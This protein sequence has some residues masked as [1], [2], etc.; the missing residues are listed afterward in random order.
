MDDSY[1]SNLKNSVFESNLESEKSILHRF[2]D[3]T[4]EFTTKQIFQT[5]ND[6][7][8]WVRMVGRQH[9]FVVVI[10]KSAHGNGNKLPKC[11]L[12]CDRGGKYRPP[13]YLLPGQTLQKNTETKKCDCPFALRGV[14]IPLRSAP[15]P[16]EGIMWGVLVVRGYHNHEPTQYLK[17]H[18]YPSRLKPDEKQFVLDLADNIAPRFILS[19]L[20]E[21]D[22]SNI[23]GIRSIYNAIYAEKRTRRG[24]LNSVQYAPSQL[25][26]KD[27]IKESRLVEYSP[28]NSCN[29][30]VD[31]PDELHDER[32][33][34]P[35]DSDEGLMDRSKCTSH[36][37][38]VTHLKTSASEK[39]K[40]KEG[41]ESSDSIQKDNQTESS[42]A[43]AK[44]SHSHF[45][46]SAIE[47]LPSENDAV[48]SCS[49]QKNKCIE[50]T[51]S[52][53]GCGLRVTDDGNLYLPCTCDEANRN[54]GDGEH[55]QLDLSM[56]QR[57][58][59]DLNKVTEHSCDK[60]L[61]L[62]SGLGQ[63]V[64]IKKRENVDLISA[65]CGDTV[66]KN[67]STANVFPSSSCR[68]T[69]DCS[70]EAYCTC[71][72]KQRVDDNSAIQTQRCS[73]HDSMEVLL[74]HSVRVNA[75]PDCMNSSSFLRSDGN[76]DVGCGLNADMN[77]NISILKEKSLP[78]HTSSSCRP[79][80]S[81]FAEYWVPVHISNLQ[82]EQYSSILLSNS[83][84]LRSCLKKD[85]VDV[86]R[87]ILVSTL[88]CCNHPYVI[89]P[90]LQPA[91]TK[92]CTFDEI[93]D[94]GGK[95]SGKLQLL[96]AMLLKLKNQGLRLLILY[97]PIC[98]VGRDNIG[99]ILEDYLRHRFGIDSYER[100]DGFGCR[101]SKKQAACNTFNTDKG[102]LFFLLET[103]ACLP[104]IK[105]S[106]V[107]AVIIYNSDWNP[108]NDLRALQKITIESNMEQINVF[109]LYSFCTI[110]ENML[111]LTKK[112]IGFGSN[113]QSV[114]VSS[115]HMLLMLGA[116]YLFSKLDEFHLD[117]DPDVIAGIAFKDSFIRDVHQELFSLSE[118]HRNEVSVKFISKAEQDEGKY[119]KSISL[120]GELTIQPAV[121]ESPH[122]FWG[123]LLDER[124]PR[125]KYLSSPP[126]RNRKRVQYFD[127][128]VRHQDIQNEE[129]PRKRKK[130]GGKKLDAALLNDGS[131]AGG[132]FLAVKKKGDGLPAIPQVDVLES[133][134]KRKLLLEQ[135]HLLLL[136]KPEILKL[137][138]VLQLPENV[139]Q[140]AERY[141]DYV[142]NNH[143]VSREPETILQAFKISVC[144]TAA[145]L[146]G[147]IVDHKDSLVLARE[148]LDF[149][150]KEDEAELIFLKMQ[151]LKEVF[152]LDCRES[153]SLSQKHLSS[154]PNAHSGKM[155]ANAK[156]VAV[157]NSENASV[158]V[159]KSPDLEPICTPR[160]SVDVSQ[161]ETSKKVQKIGKKC[162]K[163]MELLKA[164]QIKEL[165]EFQLLWEEEKARLERMHS[166]E[167]ILIRSIHD[168][169]PI[170]GDKLKDLAN[171]SA[172][173]RQELER[174]MIARLKDLQ[175]RQQADKN[176]EQQK[177]A[178]WLEEVKSWAQVQLLNKQ[179][180]PVNMETR[181]V[182]PPS[183]QIRMPEG[184][185][186]A[187]SLSE[188]LVDER[189][190]DGVACDGP[191]HHVEP[192]GTYE[193]ARKV[194]FVAS[195]TT[196]FVADKHASVHE[197]S[198]DSPSAAVPFLNGL[199]KLP[200]TQGLPAMP[201]DEA[202]P[203]WQPE[204]VL[205]QWPDGAPAEAMGS[206]DPTERWPDAALAE[207][208]G[209]T[210]PTEMWHDAAP[211]EA[212]G[213][214]DPEER[215][216]SN[217]GIQQYANQIDARNPNGS[218]ALQTNPEANSLASAEPTVMQ[219][220][221]VST[222][223][224]QP[225]PE[226]HGELSCQ[227]FEALGDQVEAVSEMDDDVL[228]V[229]ASLLLASHDESTDVSAT[230]VAESACIP[231]FR[232][233][234]QTL[235][236]I[237][238]H[239]DP[240]RESSI[241]QKNILPSISQDQDLA[242]ILNVVP[243]NP[244]SECEVPHTVANPLRTE[245][246]PP[247]ARSAHPQLSSLPRQVPTQ[248]VTQLPSD[249][250][251]N[252]LDRIRRQKDL[253]IRAHDGM[254]LRLESD[255]DKEIDEVV[256]QIRRKYNNLR[257]EA[258]ASFL[259]EKK[260]FDMKENK[261]Q[262][263]KILAEAFRSKYWLE[264]RAASGTQ[265]GSQQQVMSL[266]RTPPHL[267]PFRP[268][269]PLASGIL[270]TPV[271]D[272]TFQLP[273]SSSPV[274]P[275]PTSPFLLIP[276][277]ADPQTIRPRLMASQQTT[278]SIPTV[279]C[280]RLPAQLPLQTS[281]PPAP[282]Q[283]LLRS[284]Q[285]PAPPPPHR[286]T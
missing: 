39:L 282:F 132:G 110:E 5:R 103:H 279:S 115:C 38:D 91:L 283:P 3:Y 40:S 106:S 127:G 111:A 41:A 116:S 212:M 155:D 164:K 268:V 76:P 50:E 99:D 87:E 20:K 53:N 214:T 71:S 10:D 42:D 119:Q 170:R 63:I 277:P 173:K 34:Q 133:E 126:Q 200:A 147:Q 31:E 88:K 172:K 156:E 286:G 280:P 208:R 178:L 252:E 275:S 77:H 58:Q 17:G 18:E 4:Q 223:P 146:L 79:L 159:E 185:K 121:Q 24:S 68:C 197:V 140:L 202:I 225:V 250:L 190:P 96:D 161:R 248:A 84:A 149:S 261:I 281:Q 137:C 28:L 151:S 267:Q 157:S 201:I 269:M 184:P 174:D 74:Q 6:M 246:S 188:D 162:R 249:P 128:A 198:S 224:M 274:V 206:T 45:Q 163:Q 60:D 86:F 62:E 227:R 234:Q 207:A 117:N 253:A 7:T 218:T 92:D 193:V 255:R 238:R 191:G 102:R 57:H 70:F 9:G 78:Q 168:N 139:N 69:T 22:D 130:G 265:Q 143:R 46:N 150:C 183:E 32:K 256:A 90:S 43:D 1:F 11:T 61:T 154:L 257:E 209:V 237:A 95:A 2:R 64:S 81:R 129:S 12:I 100:I 171:N 105:L 15:I 131:E 262:M 13:K 55:M 16:P 51:K 107:D 49:S 278:S 217:F 239:E 222:S 44:G 272:V 56:T 112:Q 113:L 254:M 243:S 25:I 73:C 19:A 221:F 270:P 241:F 108:L 204:D 176:V 82:L 109:R 160:Q 75:V 213:V 229:E 125:W 226:G 118:N 35:D 230:L 85:L 23:T 122:V 52:V 138:E 203:D 83:T 89:D 205:L 101:N 36:D 251:Q 14:P 158:K 245:I 67:I 48:S 123:K 247:A 59:E 219:P 37:V 153:R 177:V 195:E 124:H 169:I 244:L 175:A 54:L 220:S 199:P 47:I 266:V 134:E 231:L 98:G 181:E 93:Y 264:Y 235:T 260:E 8:D 179:P 232:H 66:D 141:L 192:S 72:R 144:W 259:L 236:S 263:N 94:F 194:D 182:V 30:W 167:F 97:Q 148:R 135:R 285:S 166:L 240:V 152:H 211:A 196:V 65:D 21:R 189:K 29:T 210:D 216:N 271:R 104:S 215:F 80:S 27:A 186:D 242:E 145:S 120:F 180:S 273:T 233:N 276:I 258:E 228:E 142:I 114:S 284:S 33:K 165:E 136:L 26:D 187:G